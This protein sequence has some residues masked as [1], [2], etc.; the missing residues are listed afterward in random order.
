M[1]IDQML[2]YLPQLMVRKMKLDVM[3]KKLLR[4]RTPN[5]GRNNNIVEYTYANYDIEQ[6]QE[7]YLKAADMLARA[8]NA[9]D[10]VNNSVTFEV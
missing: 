3:R 9:L 4:E 1:T 5:Y 6:V 10:A 7:D 8:Q 2:V